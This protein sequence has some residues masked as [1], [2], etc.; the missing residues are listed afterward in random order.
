MAGHGTKTLWAQI[1]Q[2]IYDK[3][4]I[5]GNISPFGAISYLIGQLWY[6]GTKI[7]QSLKLQEFKTSL[8]TILRTFYC[9]VAAFMTN[10]KYSPVLGPQEDVEEGFQGPVGAAKDTRSV[11]VRTKSAT[12]P[13]GRRLSE[14]FRWMA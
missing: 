13:G 7:I 3:M 2:T 6:N 1:I 9:K 5:A 4:V 10:H 14:G 11:Q 12:G 8:A